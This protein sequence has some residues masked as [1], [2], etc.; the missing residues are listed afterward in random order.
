MKICLAILVIALSA[1]NAF[2]QSP[3]EAPKGFH[4]EVN[5][6]FSDEFSGAELDRKKWHD[7]NPNWKGRAPGK[8]MPSSVSVKDGFLQIRLSPLDPPQGDFDIAAG[9]IQSKSNEALFGYYECRMKASQLSAST[10]FWMV[11]DRVEIPAGT[12]SQELIVQFTIGNAKD[13]MGH[14]KSNAMSALKP[15]GKDTKKKKA[16]RTDRIKLKSDVADD[17][18]TYGVWWVDAN[19]LKFYADGEYVYTIN[20]STEFDDKPFRHPLTVNFVCET[21]DWQ[22]KP[23]QEELTDPKRNTSYFDYVRAYKLIKND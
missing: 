11:G 10:N 15:S 16:K 20:P 8:F 18:H 5:E 13:Y 12:L 14:M 21:F 2:S 9:T 4:W 6:A 7:H 17:F 19:T 1:A 22:P 3:P 23:T